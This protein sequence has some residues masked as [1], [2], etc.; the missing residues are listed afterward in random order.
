MLEFFKGWRRKAGCIGLMVSLLITCAW[1]RSFKTEDFATRLLSNGYW[2][3]V[4]KNGGITFACQEGPMVLHFEPNT[5]GSQAVD[6]EAAAKAH[7][8]AILLEMMKKSD[9]GQPY[10]RRQETPR[11]ETRDTN[12]EICGFMF[13]TNAS[14]EPDGLDRS[15]TTTLRVPYWAVVLPFIMLSAWLLLCKPRPTTPKQTT[16]PAPT[17]GA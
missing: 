13:G 2:K 11:E 3:V 4:S 8:E 5:M 12:T 10:K 17:T 14:G 1:M 16:E 6:K 7:N 9:A 15:V